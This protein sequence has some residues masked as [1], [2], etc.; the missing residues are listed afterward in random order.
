[1]STDPILHVRGESRFIDDHPAPAGTLHA[2]V[3]ASPVA[4][5]RLTALDV[6]TAAAAPGVHAVLTARDIPG[7]NQIGGIIADEPLLAAE[8]LD[9]IGQ[10]VALAVAATPDAARAALRRI[11]LE[12][13]EEPPIF[14]PREAVRRGELIQPPRTFALGDVDQ[15]W[16]QCDYIIEGRADTGGQEHLYLE[17]Q[18]ALALPDEQGGI[19]VLSATQS[20]TTVQKSL[21]RV[22]GLPMHQVEV[23][24]LRLGG[25]FGGK[26]DQATAWAALAA[27]AAFRL[28]KPVKLVLRRQEDMR[29]T[30]KRHPYSADYRLGLRRDGRLL[31]WEVTYY[32][33]AGAAADLSP[34]IL[35]RTLFH[36][37]NCYAIP[38]V[39]AT[40]WCCRT[41]L[42]PNTA[43]R[44]F[45]GPQALFVMEAALDQAARRLGLPVAALQ[46]ANLIEE[47]NE[48]P[49]G[50]R[51]RNVQARRCWQ[52]LH[53]RFDPD[54]R[55][56]A[57]RSFNAAHRDEKK[58]LAI[59][60]ICFGISF[61]NTMLNQ[62]NAL[63][64]IYSDGSVG[65]S[66]GA[67]EMGQGVHEKLRK[68]AARTL[69]IRPTRI[70]IESTSTQRNANTS[71]TA[72]S[73]GA[74]MNGQ[75]VHLACA[76]ILERLR[77]FA[78]RLAGS[79][80]AG[81]VTIRNE[82]IQIQDRLLPYTWEGF[83]AAAY[84]ARIS[85]S[86]HAHYATPGIYFDKNTNK[87]EAFAYHVYGAAL[88]EV[89]LDVLRG[90]CRCD[91]VRIVHD[92]GR[93]LDPRIDRG[94][95]EGGVVQGLGWMTLEEVVH[96]DKGK[97]LADSMTT[98]KVPDLF[99]A[100][101]EIELHWLERVTGGTGPF[102]SKAIGEPPF[103][104][105]IGAWFALYDALRAARPGLEL[106][107][108]A[109]LTSERLLLALHG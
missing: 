66:T 69:G 78:A 18:G 64:H 80:A 5:G 62:A 30:G 101:A 19:K 74:D 25:G 31:A 65:V 3:L 93:S 77:P 104:Y 41:N 52:E 47:G 7:E 109:P 37:A 67:V 76:T 107:Y 17:T 103:L 85:L 20:P 4:R 106:P 9:Y 46:A 45:G 100:P 86:S 10:P 16:Q 82:R 36:A 89:T 40:A 15:A 73:T 53:A 22:L 97:L 81:D 94:Q 38:N 56:A 75:A 68:V 23:E 99:F 57:F 11:A 59:M 90:T 72:A 29:Y 91:A 28:C 71:A 13:A 61:T 54:A 21:A 84:A 98:Y 51:G 24:V 102:N 95:V 6:T 34:A 2:A 44:G 14:D 33:N 27:L 49:Y 96:N 58:G 55:R 32:Q 63:V 70:R 35:D 105:G 92:V 12:Y 42:P 60:P 83:I 43:F 48:F 108:A 26:E 39:R 50:Q 79:D 1:M 8:N 88:V 87:G